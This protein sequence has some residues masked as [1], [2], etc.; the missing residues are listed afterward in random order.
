MVKHV[1]PR[2]SEQ[3]MVGLLPW[4]YLLMSQDLRVTHK[5]WS[6][7]LVLSPLLLLILRYHPT[8]FAAIVNKPSS[9]LFIGNYWPL[10]TIIINHHWPVSIP[11]LTTIQPLITICHYQPSIARYHILSLSLLL[12]LCGLFLFPLTVIKRYLALLSTISCYS[13]IHL[14]NHFQEF[15][16]IT[17]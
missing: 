9:S 8:S 14:I 13:L 12:W 7:L 11:L 5:S 4:S 3:K 2:I 15:P 6:S 17:Y 1:H 10:L 16:T